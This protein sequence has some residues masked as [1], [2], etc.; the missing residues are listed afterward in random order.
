MS[1]VVDNAEM[2][3]V[4]EHYDIFMSYRRST[5]LDLARSIVYWFRLKGFKCFLDQTELLT[6]QFNEQIYSAIEHTRYFLLLMTGDAL[7][8]CVNA[9]DWVRHEIEY[10][11]KVKGR[12]CIIPITPVTPTP[13][14]DCLPQ[15]LEFLRT[16]EVSVIDRQ[17]NFD[18]T[19]RTVVENRMP[20]LYE[21][22]KKRNLLSENE[23]QLLGTIRW[24]KRN[25][26][27]IDEDELKKIHEAAE[28][29]QI[30]NIRLQALI[31]QVEAEVAEEHDA[32]IRR[33]I[34][35]CMAD[36]GRID[37]EERGAIDKKAIELNI[38]QARLVKIMAEI[39]GQKKAGAKTN[40]KLRQL[41]GLEEMNAELKAENERL[42]A[43][44]KRGGGGEEVVVGIRR[45]SRDCGWCVPVHVVEWRQG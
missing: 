24:Y 31:D 33:L 1:E 4:H 22:I 23:L 26:G 37:S 41:H 15:T 39:E 5:G 38:P 13:F 10:A 25:D 2:S 6:G 9:E 44:G 28:E 18:S 20:V 19:L 8:R 3:V 21:E 27:T 43:M 7:D 14:P 17:K 36:D 40:D 42:V 34:E 30:N 29:Y 45:R 35:S 12:D 32:T 16:C 11:I